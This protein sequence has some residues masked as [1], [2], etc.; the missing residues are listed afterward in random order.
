MK[1]KSTLKSEAT[2]GGIR[3]KIECVYKFTEKGERY[4]TK[5]DCKTIYKY[6]ERGNEVEIAEYNSKDEL[7]KKYT[8]EYD[9][10]GNNVLGAR[11][12]H[13]GELEEKW[14]SEYDER[15]NIIKRARYEY[16]VVRGKIKEIPVKKTIYKYEYY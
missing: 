5:I 12:N 3:R 16:Q 10:R 9:E 7:E 8:Y 1:A 11:Y 13:R 4:E 15:G 14:I 2:S 6:D